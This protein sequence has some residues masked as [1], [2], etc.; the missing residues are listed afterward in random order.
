MGSGVGMSGDAERATHLAG[1]MSMASEEAARAQWLGP[2]ARARRR[3]ER[4]LYAYHGKASEQ[5]RLVRST[6]VGTEHV[7]LSLLAPGEDSL[8]TQALVDS[9]ITYE[10]VRARAVQIADSSTRRGRAFASTYSPSW[11][12]FVGRVEGLAAGL[13]AKPIGPEHMLLGLLWE[14][15]PVH[16]GFFEEHG[17]SS[18]AIQRRLAKLG[19]TVPPGQPPLKDDTRWGDYVTIRLPG[20]DAW[21]LASL[22]RQ[23]CPEGAPFGFNFNSTHAWFHT[24]EGIDLAPLVRRARRSQRARQ[25]RH[26]AEEIKPPEVRSRQ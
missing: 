5:A 16:A 4:G 19:P 22:I 12:R 6:T 21:E 11:Y 3:W 15:H 17:T 18:R 26:P 7:L 8:A 1:S 25:R 14:P 10:L 2:N 20:R 24:G 13:G 9:G 23:L